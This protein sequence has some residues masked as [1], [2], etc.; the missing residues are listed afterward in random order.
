MLIVPVAIP[1]V[2]DSDAECVGDPMLLVLD[3]PC[4]LECDP[5]PPLVVALRE[6]VP[7]P[8]ERVDVR[9]GLLPVL[10]LT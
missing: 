8:L 4:E 6:E 3:F 9:F 5:E 7:S 10:V 2:S 1:L